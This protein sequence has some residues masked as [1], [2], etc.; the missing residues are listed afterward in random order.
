MDIGIISSLQLTQKF[1]IKIARLITNTNY[2]AIGSSFI[3]S[4]ISYKGIIII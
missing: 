2:L 3:Y 4:L 1:D